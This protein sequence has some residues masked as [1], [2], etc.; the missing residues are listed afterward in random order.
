MPELTPQRGRSVRPRVDLDG[1]AVAARGG[2]RAALEGLVGGL[3]DDLYRLALRMVWHPQDAE[4]AT[5]EIL[6][7]VLTGLSTWRGDAS[8]RTWAWRVAV[9]H[10]LDRRRSRMEE[11]HWTFEAFG[12]DL[13]AGLA[14][15]DPA[16][17]PD[18]ELLAQEVRL[19]CT[20]GMLQ[21]LDRDHRLAYIL[22][23][24]FTLPSEVAADITG[25]T[26]ATH[27]KRLS[28]ARAAVRRFVADHCGIVDPANRCRCVRR[29]DRAVV[30]GRVDPERLQFAR[31]PAAPEAEA[32]AMEQLHDAAAL[33][34]AHPAYTTPAQVVAGVRRVIDA[35]A[36]GLLDEH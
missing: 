18:A 13:D 17:R 36:G 27:R 20:L 14:D 5:Q 10:L 19:G 8:V 26:P 4:D 23:E 30:L 1:L 25:V 34:R 33:L 29:V 7:K 6:V 28:R 3:S 12:D 22:G 31:H 32:V 21:C 9:R 16:H 11:A 15:G 35:T 24:V 2:D